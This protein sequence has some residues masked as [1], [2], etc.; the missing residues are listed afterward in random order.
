MLFGCLVLNRLIAEARLKGLECDQ[1][2]ERR[3][4]Q[5]AGIGTRPPDS[6]ALGHPACHAMF[7]GLHCISFVS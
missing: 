7:S 5:R 4:L 3:A 1:C 2:L 6:Q